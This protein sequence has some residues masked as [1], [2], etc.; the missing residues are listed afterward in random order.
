MS[1]HW[2][3]L[4][5]INIVINIIVVVILL[6]LFQELGT[7]MLY[8]KVKAC[9]HRVP[10]VVQNVCRIGQM[11]YR[12]AFHTSLPSLMLVAFHSIYKYL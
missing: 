1:V 5:Y 8:F 11:C 3:I 12:Q 7:I 6:F 4:I 2:V 10:K 9:Y